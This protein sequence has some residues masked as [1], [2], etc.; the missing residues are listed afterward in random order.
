MTSSCP[1]PLFVEFEAA[2]VACHL[3][4]ALAAGAACASRPS[5]GAFPCLEPQCEFNERCLEVG[6]PPRRA[7]G[8]FRQTQCVDSRR[9]TL[10]TEV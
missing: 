3:E 5:I 2:S 4:P 7:R 10:F 9:A 6:P 8:L 1:C